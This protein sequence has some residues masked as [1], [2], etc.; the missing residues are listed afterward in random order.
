M[1]VVVVEEGA[2]V[3]YVDAQNLTRTPKRH[4]PLLPGHALTI[5]NEQLPPIKLMRAKGKVALTIIHAV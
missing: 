5:P 3:A 1:V 4:E 2:S